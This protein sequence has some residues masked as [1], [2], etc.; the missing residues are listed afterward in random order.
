MWMYALN[1]RLEAVRSFL[2]FF[3]SF[4]LFLVLSY[5]GLLL[6]IL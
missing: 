2:A 6:W 5:L 4:F 1:A 3:H